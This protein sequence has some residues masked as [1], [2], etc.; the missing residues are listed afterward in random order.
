MIFENININYIVS[1]AIVLVII[2]LVGRIVI[3]LVGRI[4]GNTYNRNIMDDRELE[5]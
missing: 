3:F 2:F 5:E 1:F 4:L